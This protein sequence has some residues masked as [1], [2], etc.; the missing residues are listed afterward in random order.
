LHFCA[1][2]FTVRQ[3]IAPVALALSEAGYD[4]Q[5][6]CTRGPHWEELAAMGVRMIDVPMARSANP[7]K[8]MR[9]VLALRKV[10]RREKIEVL[11][12]HTPVAAMVGRL[13]GWMAGVPI[14]VYTAHG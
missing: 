10:L 14:I 11:H 9:S 8:A 12:V 4:V 2:D 6:A 13:A 3:F 1:V 5:C 7:L